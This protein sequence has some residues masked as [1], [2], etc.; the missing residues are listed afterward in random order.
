M[1]GN[2][3]SDSTW[4][5]EITDTVVRVVGTVRDK[6]TDNIVLV[7]RAVVFGLF[8]AIV[9]VFAL[10]ILLVGLTRGLQ[11]LLELAVEWPRA[12]YLSYFVLGGILCALGAFTMSKRRT[13]GA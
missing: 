4:A 10:V 5:T 3:L 11:S 6:T 12:V 2:P 8:A 13:P 9:G 1:A 7:A